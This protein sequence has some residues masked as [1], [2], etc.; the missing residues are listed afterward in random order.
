MIVLAALIGL[1]TGTLVNWASDWLPRF[2]GRGD[3]PMPRY[4]VYTLYPKLYE[5]RLSIAVEL[6]TALV[7]ALL[8]ATRG[9]ASAFEGAAYCALYALLL[10]IAITDLKHR[11]IAN[12]VTYPLLAIMIVPQLITGIS[13]GGD[14]RPLLLGGALTFGM[15]SLIA[16]IKPGSL[17]GGDVKLAMLIGVMFGFPQVLWALIIGVGSGGLMAA[18]LLATGRGGRSTRIPYAPFLCLG[19]MLALL[20]NPVN[21][22]LR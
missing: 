15:F 12:V 21:W 6:S 10:L 9:A 16:W 1:F 20:Y 17:G 11:L 13:A 14:V 22:Y 5:N 3:A 8:W 7:F 18:L 19:A 4:R 2:A